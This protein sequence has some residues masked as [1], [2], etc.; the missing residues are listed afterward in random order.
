VTYSVPGIYVGTGGIPEPVTIIAAGG[1]D[2][3]NVAQNAV[4]S[5]LS[6]DGGNPTP[7]AAPGDTLTVTP[8]GTNPAVTST[9]TP[10]GL[11]GQFTSSSNATISF[12]HIETLTPGAA[13]HFVVTAPG[14]PVLDGATLSV[15]VTAVDAAG[16]TV[17]G[18]P[19]TVHFTSTDAAAILPANSTLAGGTGTFSVTLNTPGLQTVTATDTVTASIT[20]TSNAIPVAVPASPAPMLSRTLEWLLVAA[21]MLLAATRRRATR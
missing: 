13:T 20:G 4:G 10:A 9:S 3:F 21:V 8:Y 2:T 15:V 18:Y 16:V 19:G 5:A 12:Q 7:P 17:T 6:I 11:Q 14:A 1:N